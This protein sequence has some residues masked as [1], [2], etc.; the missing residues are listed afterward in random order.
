[1]SNQNEKL[2]STK[3]IKIDQYSK[4]PLFGLDFIGIIDRGTNLLEI[5]PITICNL[6]CKYCFVRAGDYRNNFI[7]DWNYMIEWLKKALEFKPTDDI[8]VHIAPYGEFLLYPDFV[9]LIQEIHKL[10]KVKTIS[11]QT[12]GLLLN[13]KKIE[14]IEIAGVTRLNISFNSMEPKLA[15]RLSGKINYNVKKMIDIF[16]IVLNSKMEL[17]IAPIWFFGINDNE[18]IKIIELAKQYEELG[19][20]WPKFRLG[21]QNYLIYKTGRKLKN[22]KERDFKY[23]YQRLR[24]L[25]KKYNLKL[26]LGPHDFNIHPSISINPP[27]KPHQKIK[28]HIALPGRTPHEYIGIFNDYWS[29]KV[30]S[31]YPLKIGSKIKG[32]VIKSKNK[33]NLITI[34]V[35]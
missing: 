7:V 28:A 2:D 4:I 13:K 9:K 5:K 8:E 30:L 33:E 26:K 34:I 31:H 6:K 25:E 32:I 1:M 12:N 24:E 17:L 3:I 29:V 19:F 15:E 35:K 10:K 16:E 21:I 11:I 14:K 20:K 27:V 23:F 22:V 18:I